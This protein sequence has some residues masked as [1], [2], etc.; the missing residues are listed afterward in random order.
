MN[1]QTE[2]REDEEN[3]VGKASEGNDLT[4]FLIKSACEENHSQFE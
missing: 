4:G 3:S 1:W 2:R